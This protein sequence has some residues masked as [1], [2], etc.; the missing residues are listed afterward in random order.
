MIVNSALW[1]VRVVEDQIASIE[2]V[3]AEQRPPLS[4]A[5]PTGG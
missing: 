1:I 4:A 3:Q 5:A 2:V